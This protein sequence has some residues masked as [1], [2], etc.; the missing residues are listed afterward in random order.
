MSLNLAKAKTRRY[1][2]HMPLVLFLLEII[3]RQTK[4]I[5]SLP[6]VKMLHE[7]FSAVLETDRIAIPVRFGTLLHK[8]HFFG[9]ANAKLP[10]QV[11]GDIS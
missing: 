2:F 6:A 11:L 7:N 5:D 9:R 8:G 3:R 1:F 4:H 10:L